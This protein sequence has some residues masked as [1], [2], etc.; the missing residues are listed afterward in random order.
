MAAHRKLASLALVGLWLAGCQAPPPALAPD[1][2]AVPGLAP[3]AV[4]PAGTAAGAGGATTPGTP[5]AGAAPGEAPAHAPFT[6]VGEARLYGKPFAGAEVRVFAVGDETPIA[7]GRADAEGRFALPLQARPAGPLLRI[8][9]SD[10]A[11]TLAGVEQTEDAVQDAAPARQARAVLQLRAWRV[12]LDEVSTTAYVALL[13]RLKQLKRVSPADAKAVAATVRKLVATMAGLP[14]ERRQAVI[15]EVVTRCLDAKGERLDAASLAD[16]TGFDD[17]REIPG[18]RDALRDAGDALGDAIRHAGGATVPNITYGEGRGGNGRSGDQGDGGEEPTTDALADLT[19]TVRLPGAGY[20]GPFDL[21][22]LDSGIEAV[23]VMLAGPTEDEQEALV[24]GA[25]ATLTF[26]DL[27]PGEGYAVVVEGLSFSDQ[28]S[29]R[30]LLS[31][32]EH[33]LA[34]HG[35]VL[36]LDDAGAA[37]FDALGAVEEADAFAIEAGANAVTVSLPIIGIDLGSGSGGGIQ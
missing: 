8:V 15:A 23:R 27:T 19:V 20:P 34:R 16:R 36:V 10:G 17:L 12:V 37:R 14:V 18:F 29:M 22:G 21:L 4:A 2:A 5:A 28:Q 25:T 9:A 33:V 26:E 31:T 3:V 30:V 35:R 1:G 32:D 6:L 11:T 7:A 24:T 13:P